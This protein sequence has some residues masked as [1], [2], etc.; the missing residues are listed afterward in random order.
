MTTWTHLSGGHAIWLFHNLF[1]QSYPDGDVATPCTGLIE[2]NHHS[3]LEGQPEET[4]R[5]GFSM[6]FFNCKDRLKEMSTVATGIFNEQPRTINKWWFSNLC[7][8]WG[9]TVPDQ[10]LASQNVTQGLRH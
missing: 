5:P 7:T 4:I 2:E 3:P 8:E 6:H 1:T 9:V 10:N